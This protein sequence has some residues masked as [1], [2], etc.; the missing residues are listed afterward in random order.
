[1]DSDCG[2]YFGG[3]GG[4]L[5][6]AIADGNVST[7]VWTTALKNLFRVQMRLGMFDPD[8][9][10]PYRQY[11]G[12]HS[13]YTHYTPTIHS[14][15]THYT[16]TIHS[17]YTHYTP[18]IHPLYTH[19]IPTIY[20][21][22]A[23]RTDTLAHRELALEAARQGLVLVKNQGGKLPLSKDKIR[24]IAVVG[25]HADAT[26]AM[27]SNYHGTAPYLISPAQGMMNYSANVTVVRGLMSVSSNDTSA[28]PMAAAAAAVADA[29]VM[30]MGLDGTIEGEGND[31]YS[32]ELPGAQTQLIEAVAAAAKASDAS[33]PVV[34][35]MINGG[36]VDIAAARDNQNVDAILL[37]GY[38]GQAGGLAIADTLYG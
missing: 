4:A 12:I 16:P 11:S 29:V 7:S 14:L 26:T 2:S 10:Q 33:K 38:P 25:P 35:V 3:V 6:T 19:Y 22:A 20:P 21:L 9:A 1:M 31:R 32:I 23:T 8:D 37:A 36:C 17:L 28:I 13:L 15:Y 27:Q 30:V 5:A 34:L 18:T 24:N